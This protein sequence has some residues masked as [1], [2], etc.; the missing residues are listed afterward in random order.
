MTKFG[1]LF[2]LQQCVA[3]RKSFTFISVQKQDIL[4]VVII[5][6][7][8]VRHLA[9]GMWRCQKPEYGISIPYVLFQVAKSGFPI[10]K[11]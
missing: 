5:L 9:N 1:I 2:Y 6:I 3:V 11:L 10:S 7:S 4:V 8:P